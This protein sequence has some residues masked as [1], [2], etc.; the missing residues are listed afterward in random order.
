MSKKILKFVY[1]FLLVFVFACEKSEIATATQPENKNSVNSTINNVSQETAIIVANNF[2][3]VMRLNPPEGRAQQRTE[4]AKIVEETFT[5]KTMNDYDAIH[6][7]NYV[8]GGYVV[9]SADN[10]V[11]PIQAYSEDGTFDRN[12]NEIPDPVVTWIEEEK[13]VVENLKTTNF[14]PP[15]PIQYQWNYLLTVIFGNPAICAP[16]V[17]QKGPLVQTRWG[18]GDTYNNLIGISCPTEIGGQAPTGCVATAMAQVMKFHGF[19]DNYNWNAMPNFG[20][21]IHTQWIM[22][23]IGVSIGMNYTCEGSWA[24]SSQIPSV[25]M[26]NFGYANANFGYYSTETVINNLNINKPVIISA[27]RRRGGIYFPWN[28]YAN[29]HA[30]VCDGYRLF[31]FRQPQ[32]NGSCNNVG[33]ALLS[34]N[35]GWRGKYNGYYNDNNFSPNAGELDFNYQKKLTYNIVP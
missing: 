12:I 32:P 29:G 17:I 19:P 3:E 35:W 1:L 26:N 11:S 18:Q 20:G 2:L 31:V 15:G 9:V 28:D 24:D 4:P 23:N 6:V 34:M 16:F 21:T 22:R 8:D 27:G 14:D 10:R 30:W 5:L 13:T 25:F 7:I 33:M